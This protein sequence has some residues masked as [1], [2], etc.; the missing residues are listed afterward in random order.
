MAASC[1]N[2]AQTLAAVAA[3]RP[4]LEPVLR[5]FEDVLTARAAL[6]AELSAERADAAGMA[7]DGGPRL[8]DWSGERAE[9]GRSLLAGVPLTGLRAAVRRTAETLLPLLCAKGD[10]AAHKAALE[11]FF[12]AP[13]QSRRDR[14]DVLAEAV[15]AGDASTF[16]RLAAEAGLPPEVLE[17]VAEFVLSPPLRALADQAG[18]AGQNAP[19][20]EAGAWRQ[21]YCPVCSSFPVMGW[22][23]KPAFDEK[24]AFLSGG[25]GKKHLYCSLCGTSWTFRRGACPACGE[26]GNGV[27]EILRESGKSRGERLDWCTKCKS[28]C[29]TV[30][31]REC[32]GVPDMDAMAL[33]MMHLDMVA[34]RKGLSPLK[35]SFWN[36]F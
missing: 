12:L 3:R 15:L 36:L 33:G 26:E 27:M 10:V 4:A 32:G 21:G 2:V 20:D 30:D 35:A 31:L 23:D 7:E 11:A 29:P 14:R 8:P 13:A 34:A 17:F 6:A 5:A 24:N 25:G 9:Q 18:R 1:Q 28:Y 16:Q 19:W 22:L